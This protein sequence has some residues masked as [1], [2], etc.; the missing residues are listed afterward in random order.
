M[1]MTDAETIQA[2]IDKLEARKADSTP[3]PWDFEYTDE[4]IEINAGSAR[5]RWNEAHTSGI[6]ASSWKT[7]D[8]ILEVEVF[9][10]DEDEADLIAGNA[11]LITTL[12]RTIDALLAI[13]RVEHRIALRAQ[14]A[15]YGN[16][17]SDQR[18]LDLA[19][20]ILGEDAAA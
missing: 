14:P 9:D 7:T 20:A 12:H 19:R 18:V 13:L 2:A 4:S 11:E 16:L 10:L 6:P 17:E 15:T 3:G 8:R 1:T 5:T